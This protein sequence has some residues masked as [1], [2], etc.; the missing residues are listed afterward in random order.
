LKKY[1]P[2][3]D[4]YDKY[5]V[6][7]DANRTVLSLPPIINSE[8]TKISLTTKNVFIE[9]TGT[10]LNKLKICLAVVA[11]QFSHHCQGEDQFTVEQVEIIYEG[12][13][14][15][16]E[17]TPSFTYT[18]FEVKTSE[19]N[20]ILGLSLTTEKITECIEKMGLKV[21]EANEDGSLVTVE[22]PPTRS[23]VMHTCDIAED[24]G[25]AYGYNNIVKVFPP[26]NTVGK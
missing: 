17:S 26:T 21:K 6:F 15:R 19:I 11:G 12:D 9:M 4:G 18:D 13:E 24:V 8:T 5:P 7:Y 2:I 23:D 22:V 3:L 16:N 14:S 10:D 20:K 1:L 25:I